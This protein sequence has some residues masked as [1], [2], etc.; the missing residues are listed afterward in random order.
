MFFSV[1]HVLY[2]FLFSIVLVLLIL[3]FI[4]ILWRP[5]TRRSGSRFFCFDDLKEL[6]RFLFFVVSFCHVINWVEISDVILCAFKF[7]LVAKKRFDTLN[8]QIHCIATTTKNSIHFP[9]PSNL[10]LR[11]SKCR[12]TTTHTTKCECS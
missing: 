2:S 8:P 12:I 7:L 11:Q 4:K 3:H 9:F 6:N 1:H 5:I 10:P